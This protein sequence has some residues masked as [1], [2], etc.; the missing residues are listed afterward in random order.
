MSAATWTIC[1]FKKSSLSIVSMIRFSSFP[2]CQTLRLDWQSVR[3]VITQRMLKPS[4]STNLLL[5]KPNTHEIVELLPQGQYD[6]VEYSFLEGFVFQ[7]LVSDIE[8]TL[9]ASPDYVPIPFPALHFDVLYQAWSRVPVCHGLIHRSIFSCPQIW[10]TLSEAEP[11]A[12][13]WVSNFAAQRSMEYIGCS[14]WY[15]GPD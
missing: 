13:S 1:T 10:D 6:R 9:Q 11:V 4:L 8:G 7:A 14:T 5:C 15:T 2:W 12:I 3:L